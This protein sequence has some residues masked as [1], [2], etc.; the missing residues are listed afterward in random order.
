MSNNLTLNI[1]KIKQEKN[2]IDVLADIFFHAVFGEKISSE[3]LER[4]KWYGIYA[5]DEKQEFF[6]LKIPLSMGEL[7]LQQIK[8]LSLI[9]K[10]Y[11]NNSL[12][13]SSSQKVELKDIKIFNLPNI[14]NILQ[15]VGLETSFEA[16]HTV[17][18]VLTCPINTIDDSQIFNVSELANKLNETFIGNKKFSNLPNKLQMAISGHEEGCNVQ[19]TPDV[20]FNAIKDN[21]DKVLFAI[22]VLDINLGYITSAQV[23]NAAKAIAEIYRDFGDRENPELNSFQSLVKKWGIHKFFDVVN[24]SMNYKIQR[25][26]QTKEHTIPRKPRM[27]INESNVEEQSYIG[28]KINSSTIHNTNLDYLSSLLE[29]YQASKIR[30]SHKGNIIILDV[31][32]SQAEK[33]AKE[34]E[35]IDFNPFA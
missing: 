13:F 25:N 14:F 26:V 15:E 9:S 32:T 27:G 10:E 7:N 23:I 20:S 12:V 22:K 2:E 31:P 19:I 24:S 35:K 8:A 11:A 28:C 1:E 29:K 21:K 5:Q 3:D 16:G 4:F 17:R 30:I 6:E 33:L 18:R 34:L